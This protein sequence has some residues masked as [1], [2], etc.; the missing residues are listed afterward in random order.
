MFSFHQLF[1]LLKFSLIFHSLHPKLST[2]QFSKNLFCRKFGFTFSAPFA[3]DSTFNGSLISQL[4]ILFI[5]LSILVLAWM[6]KQSSLYKTLSQKFQF[7]KFMFFVSKSSQGIF[8]VFDCNCHKNLSLISLGIKSNPLSC[9]KPKTLTCFS[10]F[11]DFKDKTSFIS[12][13]YLFNIQVLKS[14]IF[15]FIFATFSLKFSNFDFK[16]F[17][18]FISVKALTSDSFI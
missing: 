2:I 11:S 4:I 8:R 1:N 9:I 16:S 18:D 10:C 3:I 6:F 17:S 7:F 15:S 13:L 12:H 14:S 5:N